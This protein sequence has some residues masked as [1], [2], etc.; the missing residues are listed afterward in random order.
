MVDQS[1]S[2]PPPDEDDEPLPPDDS[3]EATAEAGFTDHQVEEVKRRKRG[4]QDS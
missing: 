2:A 4:G 1:E 3:P